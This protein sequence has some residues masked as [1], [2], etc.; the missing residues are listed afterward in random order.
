MTL[1]F[2]HDRL[3]ATHQ[4]TDLEQ[5]RALDDFVEFVF[6][7]ET[8]AVRVPTPGRTRAEALRDAL[9]FLSHNVSRGASLV[10]VYP[11]FR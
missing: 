10:P 1:H 6:S 5:V 3:V 9:G 4:F 11:G 8:R 2:Y 7:R